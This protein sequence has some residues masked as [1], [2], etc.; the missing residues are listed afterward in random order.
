MIF[1]VHDRSFI[2]GRSQLDWWADDIR[3]APS[4]GALLL[5]HTVLAPKYNEGSRLFMGTVLSQ[6]NSCV[7]F[8]IHCLDFAF[9]I[10]SL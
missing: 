4:A 10:P 7:W 3:I 9:Q 1:I 6:V 5:G 8:D 2:N